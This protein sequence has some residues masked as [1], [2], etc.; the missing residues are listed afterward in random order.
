MN[1]NDIK[2]AKLRQLL[3]KMRDESFEGMEKSG[4]QEKIENT[5]CDK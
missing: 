2:D 3:I 5:I 4:K 1:E